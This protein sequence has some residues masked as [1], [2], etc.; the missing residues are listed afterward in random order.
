VAFV[1]LIIGGPFSL[2][3]GEPGSEP[4]SEQRVSKIRS[5]SPSTIPTNSKSSIVG[6]WPQSPLGQDADGAE[7]P[8]GKS[9]EPSRGVDP[10]FL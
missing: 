10:P 9:L 5:P 1:L 4:E 2:P 7:M 8:H 3:V 6:T